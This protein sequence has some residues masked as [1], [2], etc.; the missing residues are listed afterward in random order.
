MKTSRLFLQWLTV[1]LLF[2]LNVV[3]TMA[4]DPYPSSDTTQAVCQNSNEPYGVNLT[5]SSTYDWSINDPAAGTIT[6][7]STPNLI[8]VKWTKPGDFVLQVV[9]TNKY[10]C[11]GDTVSVQVKVNPLPVVDSI[12]A[13]TCSGVAAGVALPVLS[14]NGLVVDK[15]DITAVVASG[16]TGT[17]TQGLAISVPGAIATDE[18]ANPT[19]TPL[20]VVYT[21]TPYTGAC[22][23]EPFTVTITVNPRVNTSPIYHN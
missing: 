9:E 11:V 1:L 15:W 10:H 12:A 2:V 5:D 3:D 16:L 7:G 19:T 8:T 23:G 22:A 17:A 14:A 13:T 18:F 6:A 21:V 20:T 4:A